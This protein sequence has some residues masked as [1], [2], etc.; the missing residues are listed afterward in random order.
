MSRTKGNKIGSV[1][2]NKPRKRWLVEYYIYDKDKGKEIVKR[3]TVNTETEGKE[4]LTNLQYQK[5]N[6][7]F[8]ENNGI[9]LNQLMR[10]NLK[11]KLDMNLITETQY[12]RVEKTIIA[13][14]KHDFVKKKIDQITSTEIQE[15]VNLFIDHSNSYIRK[16]IEQFRQAF[17]YAQNKGYITKN[18]MVDVIKPKSMKQDREVRA[19]TVEEQ[20]K[21]TNYLMGK[22]IKEEAHKNAYLLQMFCGLRIGEALALRTTDIDLVHN[23]LRVNKTLTK[24]KNDSVIMG[25]Q[26]KTYAGMREIPIPGFI[27]ESL[28]NQ[29]KLAKDEEHFDNQ[30]FVSSVS[31]YVNPANVNRLLKDRMKKLGIDTGITTHSLRHTFGTRCVEAGMRAVALQRLMGHTDISTTLNTYTSVFNKYKETEL[32]KVND[33]YLSNNFFKLKS[34]MQIEAPIEDDDYEIEV[35]NEGR[36]L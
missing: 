17:T 20:E 26:T 11:R 5:K 10:M 28:I 12:A 6:E 31:K 18:P 29:I 8:I 14:E 21:F 9:P 1:Y 4:F 2:Y 7:V 13:M 33:Y 16:V 25:N 32:E 34:P 3:K 30:L 19:L 15:Y 36:D 22:T 24:D 35:E 27:K 23:I